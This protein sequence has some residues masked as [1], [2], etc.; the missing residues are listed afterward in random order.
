MSVDS[1]T[2]RRLTLNVLALFGISEQGFLA[3]VE[4]LSAQLQAIPD[5]LAEPQAKDEEAAQAEIDA[6]FGFDEFDLDGLG[7]AV[8]DAGGTGGIVP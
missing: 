2:Q 1:F 6:L 8:P 3:R 4:Q 7:E 5:E